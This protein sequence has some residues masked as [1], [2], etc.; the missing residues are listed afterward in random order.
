MQSTVICGECSRSIPNDKINITTD[1]AHCDNCGAISK[2]SE[3][4]QKRDARRRSIHDFDKPAGVTFE[5]TLGG[6]R[7]T[8]STRSTSAFFLIPFTLVWSGFSVGI[9]YGTQIMS[10]E[11]NLVFSLFGIPFLLGSI[12]LFYASLMAIAGKIVVE[13]DG[14]RGRIFKGIGPFGRTKHFDWAEIDSVSEGLSGSHTNGKEHSEIILEGRKRI[15]FGDTLS[16]EKR[17]YVVNVI[18]MHLS[19]M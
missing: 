5:E 10:G 7:L 11:F 12:G 16:D 8:T 15:T 13:A 18:R 19:R 6:F 14:Q 3:L 4:V 1:L 9:L 2:L 17:F